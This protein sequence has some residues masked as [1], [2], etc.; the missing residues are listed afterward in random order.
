MSHTHKG[1]P[2]DLE[3]FVADSLVQ[4]A[5]GLHRANTEIQESWKAEGRELINRQFFILPPNTVAA[6][7]TVEFDV[8]VT[9]STKGD[10]KVDGKARLYVVD[11]SA[12]ATGAVAHE[13][14]SRVRFRVQVEQSIF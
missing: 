7:R 8:A 13:R 6:D 14:V 12:G 9:A 3:T 11:A 5:N 2:M 10:V 1:E 4:I